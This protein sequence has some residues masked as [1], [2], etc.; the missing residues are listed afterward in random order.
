MGGLAWP[1]LI[2]SP[3]CPEEACGK[4]GCTEYYGAVC[5]CENAMVLWF[6]RRRVGVCDDMMPVFRVCVCRCML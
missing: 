1:D 6:G 2:Q 5:V 3:D 4:G